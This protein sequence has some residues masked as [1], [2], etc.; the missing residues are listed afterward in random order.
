MVGSHQARSKKV[1]QIFG[2]KI[3]NFAYML[4][5]LWGRMRLVKDISKKRG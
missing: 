1:G 5:T 2:T 3:V 4:P